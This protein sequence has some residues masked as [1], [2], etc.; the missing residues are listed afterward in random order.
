M[1]QILYS[2]DLFKMNIIKH[3]LEENGIFCAIFDM[4][5]SQGGLG[6]VNPQARLMVNDEDFERA[7]ELIKEAEAQIPQP[8]D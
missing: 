2:Q 7:L 6:L 1:K 3:M 5:T 8:E 4:R